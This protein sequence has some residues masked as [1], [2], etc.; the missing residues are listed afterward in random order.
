MSR[1]P[2]FAENALENYNFHVIMFYHVIAVISMQLRATVSG[3][4]LYYQSPCRGPW[5]L[6]GPRWEE[7]WTGSHLKLKV[8]DVL[9]FRGGGR[10]IHHALGNAFSESVAGVHVQLVP[11]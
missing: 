7:V 5:G 1:H 8:E 4:A 2:R 10:L 3:V 6:L 9:R 11:V